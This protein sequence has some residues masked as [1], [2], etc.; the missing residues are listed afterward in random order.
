MKTT[1]LPDC[2]MPDGAEP[3]VAYR[4]IE[5]E[6]RKRSLW[7]APGCRKVIYDA[8]SSPCTCKDVYKEMQSQLSD[9]NKKLD[10]MRDGQGTE[11]SLHHENVELRRQLSEAREVITEIVDRLQPMLPVLLAKYRK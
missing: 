8:S 11:Y 7:H 5:G 3:C 2:M 6:L 10:A 9:A 4:A 1:I